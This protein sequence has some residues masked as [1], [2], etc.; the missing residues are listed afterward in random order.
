MFMDSIRKQTYQYA[1]NKLKKLIQNVTAE[2][3]T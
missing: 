2:T 1:E 3:L